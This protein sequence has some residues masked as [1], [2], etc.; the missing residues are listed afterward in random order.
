[1]EIRTRSQSQPHIIS[2]RLLKYVLQAS[3]VFS[4]PHYCWLIEAIK[5]ND[6]RENGPKIIEAIYTE[7]RD[8]IS[9]DTLRA[10]LRAVLPDSANVVTAI[11]VLAIK[12]SED[13][14]E[15][16]KAIYV[17]EGHLDIMIDYL[18]HGAKPYNVYL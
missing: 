9:R 6:P 13:K 11:Y 8:L 18:V 10:V 14:E 17:A 16:Y 12:S 3:H 4:R 15:R 2:R 7:I 5:Q 1:M